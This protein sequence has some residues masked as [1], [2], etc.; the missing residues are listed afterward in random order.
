MPRRE[1]PVQTYLSDEEMRQFNEWAEATDKTRSELL[2]Q[3]VLQ[4]LDQDRAARLESELTEM[5]QQLN[6]IQATLGDQPTH[7]HKPS[8]HVTAQGSRSVEKA[9]EILMR[10]RENHG[11]VIKTDDVERAIEDI[12]GADDRTLK[13]YKRLF[14]KRGSLFEH[15]GERPVWTTEPNMWLDW[16]ESFATLETTDEVRKAVEPYPADFEKAV[17]GGY[18]IELHEG[19]ADD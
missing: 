17:N 11:E 9:R 4:Y 13:K 18:G 6:E 15:P 12:A 16:L 7:T 5:K 1:N 10:I 2:R 19:V 8:G 3:A 14:R